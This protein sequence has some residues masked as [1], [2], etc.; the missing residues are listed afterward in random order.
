[1][2]VTILMFGLVVFGFLVGT[3]QAQSV[4]EEMLPKYSPNAAVKR[5]P[6]I[7]IDS[8]TMGAFYEQREIFDRNAQVISDDNVLKN[9]V[10]DGVLLTLDKTAMRQIGQDSPQ[11]LS[12]PMPD[13]KG[14][15]I[16]L[17]LIKVNIFAEGFK[18]ETSA[19]TSEN[20]QKG[21]GVHYRGM[22][23]NEPL[24]LV[25]ISI[26]EN[27]IMG[28]IRSKTLGNSALGRLSG[29]NRNNTH[30]FFDTKKLKTRPENFCNVR[31]TKPEAE[32]LP[33]SPQQSEEELLARFVRIYVEAN[34]DVFQ[35]KGSVGATMA[36][37]T[38]FFNQSATLFANDGIFVSLQ[39]TFVWNSASPYGA[40]TDAGVHLNAFTMNRPT[41]NGNIAHLITLTP[42]GGIAN[43][44]SICPNG[45]AVSGI[46]PDF[47]TVPTFSWTVEVFTHETGHN[48]GSDHT[49]A[50]VWNG[51]NTAIDGCVAIEP[52]PAGLCPAPPAPAGGGTIM[53]YCHLNAVGINFLL[54][55]G[56]QPKALILNRIAAATC[57]ADTARAPFDF[58]N[59][60]KTDVGIFRPNGANGAEWWIN[61]SSNNTTFAASFGNSTDK[62]VPADYT[63]DGRTDVAIFRP[64]SG[65]WFVLRSEDSSF[66][67]FPFGTGTDIPI[68]GDF[69]GDNKADAAVYRPSTNNWFIQKSSGGT[70]ILTFGAAGDV[71]VVGNY[72][73]DNKADIAIFRA[74]GANGAEWWIR[75]SSNGT[76][77]ALTFGAGTD[78]PVQ[79]DFT[80]DGKTD[81]AVWRAAT[82]QWFVSRSEDF[83]FYA[84]P[85]GANGDVPVA[86]DYDGDGRFDAGVFRPTSNTWFVQRST[87]GTLIQAFGANGDRPIP[88]AYVP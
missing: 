45:Y 62:I 43:L 42:Y 47:Q 51:N 6:Q 55:F 19:P 44:D 53:S 79:G 4:L 31:S 41:Y 59:D 83:S 65:Q 39:E 7:V 67:A 1:M 86:G 80:G 28:S 85:F 20:Y 71:P 57:L 35:N 54:G 36:Y 3:V 38:G 37:V 22:I 74:N 14:G 77:F 34:F 56:T 73:G 66:Y 75:R 60:S 26:F 84:F 46:D 27:E 17:E 5:I 49:Q 18:V 21:L 13:G 82:G 61:R 2:K 9:A 40:T 64:S 8:K 48:L 81:V 24:S 70:D 78:K 30:I 32:S 33:I 68:S 10:S 87:A 15:I 63:G 88:N 12:L 25:A 69:D 58:D 23:K 52:G 29:D 50:C 11:Y 16:E 72:D 76:V